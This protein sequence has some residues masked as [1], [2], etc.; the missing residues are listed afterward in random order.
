MTM[1][2][3]RNSMKPTTCAAFSAC[4]SFFAG[5]TATTNALCDTALAVSFFVL[6]VLVALLL[7]SILVLPILISVIVLIVLIRIQIPK[8][9]KQAS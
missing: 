5:N 4:Q 9:V 6:S 7:R 3:S 2:A 1:K 8:K